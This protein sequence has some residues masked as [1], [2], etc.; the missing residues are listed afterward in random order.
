LRDAI[1]GTKTFGAS[2][3]LKELLVKF[4]FTGV[5][6]YVAARHQLAHKE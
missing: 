1:F 4:R 5:N 6:V 2:A 3:P